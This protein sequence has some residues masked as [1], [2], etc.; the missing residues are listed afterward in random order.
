MCGRYVLHRPIDE[1]RTIFAAMGDMP[2][3]PPSWN[4]APTQSALV[5]RIA[6]TGERRFDLLH[7][8]LVPHFTTDLDL[9]P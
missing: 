2:N 3:F 4:I 1:L 5:L 7:W 8:G 9:S 6:P